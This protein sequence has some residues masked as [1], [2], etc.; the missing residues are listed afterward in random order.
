VYKVA[1]ETSKKVRVLYDKH[2][3]KRDKKQA[4]REATKKRLDKIQLMV[5]SGGKSLLQAKAEVEKEERK[6]LSLGAVLVVRGV[7]RR[8]L[9]SRLAHRFLSP[10]TLSSMSAVRSRYHIE[11]ERRLLEGGEGYETADDGDGG[12]G[13]G[14]GELAREEV[15]AMFRE[16]KEHHSRAQSLWIHDKPKPTYSSVGLYKLNAVEFSLA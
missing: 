12:G 2:K 11:H 9:V 5:S 15:K 7:V 4:D 8:V 14:G 6:P 10:V 13:G 3:R 1:P 16:F